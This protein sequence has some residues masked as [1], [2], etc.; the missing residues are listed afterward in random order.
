MLAVGADIVGTLFKHTLHEMIRYAES[1][2]SLLC[3]Q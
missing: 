2:L 1:E 3:T